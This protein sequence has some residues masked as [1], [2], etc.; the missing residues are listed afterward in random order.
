MSRRTHAEIA[1]EAERLFRLVWYERYTRDPPDP[2][3][4]GHETVQGAALHAQRIEALEGGQAAL[5]ERMRTNYDVGVLNGMLAALRWA[6]G[7]DWDDEAL[8]DT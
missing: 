2:K 1:E 4:C 8:F 7:W 5:C 3:R 6:R